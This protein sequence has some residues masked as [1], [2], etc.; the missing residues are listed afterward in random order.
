VMSGG[1]I[2]DELRRQDFD[3]KRMLRAALEAGRLREA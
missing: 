1:R 3:R 2:T